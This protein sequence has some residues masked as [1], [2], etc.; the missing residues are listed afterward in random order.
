MTETELDQLVDEIIMQIEDALDEQ[1]E[2][3]DFETSAG[4]LTITLAD[5][6]Q[7]IINRQV[8]AM[9]LWLAA[10]SGGYHFDYDATKGW[11]D[12]RSGDSFL[13]ILN[14]CLSEQSGESIAL[15]LD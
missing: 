8:S 7:I 1:D 2:D 12:D 11:L 15:E 4:I 5:R 13:D 3:I 10:K 6:S 9:Q 14:R